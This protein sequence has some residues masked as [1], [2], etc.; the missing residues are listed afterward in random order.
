MVITN[1]Q[2]TEFVREWEENQKTFKAPKV[3]YLPDTDRIDLSLLLASGV[4]ELYAPKAYAVHG[5]C[6]TKK[7]FD[8]LYLPSL[9]YFHTDDCRVK[10]LHVPGI[11]ERT[12]KNFRVNKVFFTTEEVTAQT[13]ADFM[14]LWLLEKVNEAESDFQG[15][16]YG[17]GRFNF[18][19]Y[20]PGVEF[21]A[22]LLEFSAALVFS[23]HLYGGIFNFY[24][25]SKLDEIRENACIRHA[26]KTVLEA[27]EA[28]EKKVLD[29]LQSLK[30]EYKLT[31]EAAAL[32]EWGFLTTREWAFN[33]RRALAAQ[34]TTPEGIEKVKRERAPWKIATCSP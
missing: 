13:A 27:I 11:A 34:L 10:K 5:S 29:Y 16:V 14:P 8:V 12:G 3:L 33:E 30:E 7:S 18:E 1:E 9:K 25:Q 19:T 32:L 21:E 2:M 24:E 4:K 23:C 6:N 15:E 17:S 20:D 26:K 28:A 31:G 22:F